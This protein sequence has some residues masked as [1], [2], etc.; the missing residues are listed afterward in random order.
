MLSEQRRWEIERRVRARGAVTTLELSEL[1]QVSEMT[2]RRDLKALELAGK[3]RQT[4]GGAVEASR[5]GIEQEFTAKSSHRPEVK[6]LLARYAARNLVEAGDC[7]ILDPGSTVAAM[8]DE[9]SSIEGLTVATNGLVTLQRLSP[10]LPRLTVLGTGGLLREKSLSFVGPL[11]EAFFQG[12]FAKTYFISAVGYSPVAGLTDP[13]LLDTQVK[14]AMRSAA[15]RVVAILDSSKFGIISTN[16]VMGP[17][18]PDILVTDEGA[19]AEPLARLRD[20][21]VDVRVVSSQ[22]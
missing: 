14:K 8:I 20:H 5:M 18:E 4:R 16:Q 10:F 11:A 7:L 15:G 17:W 21:G 9:L 2:I 1:F 13:H 6:A 3:L 12:F 19:P 22:P